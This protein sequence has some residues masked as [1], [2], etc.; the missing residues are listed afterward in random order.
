M[1]KTFTLIMI[2][3]SLSLSIAGAQSSR[4]Q[5]DVASLKAAKPGERLSVVETGGR[6]AATGIDLKRLIQRAYA[7]GDSELFPNEIVGGPGWIETDRFDIEARPGGDAPVARQQMWNM[8]RS[9]LEDRFQLK[10]HRE[11]R[12]L[13]VYNLVIGKNGA[14][15]KL[16]DDQ[17]VPDVAAL[18]APNE[19]GAAPFFDPRKPLPRG[20]LSF[21]G[22]PSKGMTLAGSA[23]PLAKLTATLRLFVQRPIIDKTD[24]TGLFDL[25]LQF[26]PDC[27]VL[28]ACGPGDPT[29]AG[30]SLF[31]EIEQELGL[32][33]ESAKGL[34]EVLVI[35]SVQ[36][37][38]E[39]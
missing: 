27:G 23:V 19:R 21:T 28:F 39:N 11:M 38:T 29:P 36:H 7:A 34:V 9:L 14:K 16:S 1:S 26:N 25:K 3:A 31:S 22:D 24:L 10:T 17:N 2:V 18:T 20:I 15:I 6:F 30:P 12:E 8:V 13:P 33:L 4:S 35:D 37:P 32:K 5:F